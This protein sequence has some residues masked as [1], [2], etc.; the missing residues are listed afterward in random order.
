MAPMAKVWIIDERDEFLLGP[1]SYLW[2]IRGYPQWGRYI[3]RLEIMSSEE[4]TLKGH[5][6]MDF[7]D[8][9]WSRDVLTDRV[10]DHWC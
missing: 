4:Y 8:F 7:T 2:L 1:I 3:T 9:G 5:H 10:S 6:G